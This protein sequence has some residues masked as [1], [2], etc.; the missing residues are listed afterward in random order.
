[1]KRNWVK[2]ERILDEKINQG[3]NCYK[4]EGGIW[5]KPPSTQSEFKEQLTKV[6]RENR[7]LKYRG[8]HFSFTV[9]I[10]NYE[11]NKKVRFH[12]CTFEKGIKCVNTTFNELIDFY[13]S[14]F[15]SNQI[16]HLTDFLNISIF[17]ETTFKKAVIF[18]HNKVSANTYISFEKA[19]FKNGLDISN[20]NFW[21]TLQVYGIKVELPIPANSSLAFYKEQNLGNTKKENELFNLN[22]R[23]YEGLR[24]TYRRI[25]Q[26]FRKNENNIDA[27]DFHHHEMTVFSKELEFKTGKNDKKLSK[28][29]KN[30]IIL[31]FNKI[32]N[33]FNRSWIRGV[34]FTLLIGGLFYSIS[35]AFYLFKGQI[36]FDLDCFVE[37]MNDFI[38]YINPL[39]LNHKPYNIE[40]SSI[41]ILLY[42][43]KIMIGYGY[44][45]TIQAFRKY[46]KN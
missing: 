10:S 20:S 43:G 45:Q 46:G 8:C 24:E 14:T 12:N 32:S 31:F 36:V 9:D 5:L 29:D 27:L 3:K 2:I 19:T 25:K 33:D 1:M 22:K 13:Q 30:K 4:K 11:F 40:N 15:E 34:I 16:F 42:F 18:R 6:I 39:N 37:T 41:I 28:F 44:Y 38:S 21:C 26:E 23:T 17:S 35:S 7:E